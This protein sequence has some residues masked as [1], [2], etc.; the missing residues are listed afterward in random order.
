MPEFTQQ[1]RQRLGG[2]ID[3]LARTIRHFDED[4]QRSGYRKDEALNLMTKNPARLIR[5]QAVRVRDNVL[6][7]E[8]LQKHQ[9]ALDCGGV[10][11]RSASFFKHLDWPLANA[12][13]NAYEPALPIT[14]ARYCTRLPDSC[15]SGLLHYLLEM[16]EGDTKK[17]LPKQIGT[18]QHSS[19]AAVGL[20]R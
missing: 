19:P 13:Y 6:R 3:E 9:L 8:N 10:L 15:L 1:H 11:S 18:I 20:A 5:D 4:S 14:P 12:T 2:A 7:F 17:R 16:A